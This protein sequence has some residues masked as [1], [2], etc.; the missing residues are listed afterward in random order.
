MAQSD[1]ATFPSIVPTGREFTLGTF[2]TK[3]YRALSGAT[4][5]RSFGNKPH[6]YKLALTYQNLRDPDTIELL[7]HYDNTGGGF[8]RFK[9]PNGIFAGMA[10]NLQSF[11]QEPYNIQWEYTG[12]PVVQSVYRG[13]SNVTI[14]LQ[15]EITL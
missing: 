3:T 2:P 12:P 14:E 8:A 15:G 4:V 5:K 10:D 6:S 13:I 7:R 1:T 11:I 9:L